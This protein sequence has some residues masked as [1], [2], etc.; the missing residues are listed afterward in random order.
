M[1]RATRH[2][3]GLALVAALVAGCGAT[4]DRASRMTLAALLS[5]VPPPSPSTTTPPTPPCGDVTA[6]LRPPDS[7][8]APGAMPAGSF[9]ERIERRGRLIAGIDQNT[10]LFAY[11]NPLDG[12][13]EGFEIDILRELARAIFGNPNAIE[14]KAITTAQRIPAVQDRSVDIVADAITINCARRKQVDFSSVYYDAG[15]RVLV[16]SNSTVRSIRDLG[17][18]R[19][20]AT[21]DSTSI[22]NIADSIPHPIPVAV[23]QRT[24]CLVALQQ[25]AVDAISTDDAILLGFKAQD[26][27]TKIVGARFTDEPYGM[28]ISKAHPDFVRFVNGA[29]DQM[30]S[31]GAWRRIYARWLGRFTPTPAP[32]QAHYLP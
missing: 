28:A 3:F 7:M 2:L 27:Y 14:F 8:P 6:S 10:L 31:D 26:P 29:L 21:I 30:R 17:R 24:D 25:G 9:M 12:R 13:L 4:S 32:P 1:R 23:P 11:F 16:P 19:V 5:P 18:K 22:G 20:C 15:Q